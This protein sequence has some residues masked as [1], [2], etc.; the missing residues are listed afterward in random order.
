MNKKLIVIILTSLWLTACSS[1]QID[2]TSNKSP[3]VEISKTSSLATFNRDAYLFN[4]SIDTGVV[5]PL[6]KGYRQITP[7][8]VN[9]GISNVFSNLADVPN[10][11][12]ALLQFKFKDA[13]SDT[14]R[15]VVNSTLGL[16][17][18]FDVATKME[19]QKHQED[20]GQTLAVWGVP[21][22]EYIML[23]ILG[24]STMRD[25]VGT[26]I[27]TITNP[28]F[29]FEDSLVYYTLDKIDQ[30][31]DLLSVD[32]LL[33]DMSDDDYNSLR[34]AWLQKRKYLINDGKLD[35]QAIEKKKSL[36]DELEDLD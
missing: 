11:L 17:G 27:D 1:Q 3:S 5:K 25:G 26:I 14:G 10:A 35:Q 30:R 2:L 7:E 12:N 9:T 32:G 15:F 23:P 20:F 16:G 34:D 8:F 33:K 22:G 21:S 28:S 13:A 24:P 36:I 6:A 31:A 18:V 4:K 19:L 29:F